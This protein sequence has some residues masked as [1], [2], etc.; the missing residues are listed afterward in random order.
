[1]LADNQ[2]LSH[3]PGC[4]CIHYFTCPESAVMKNHVVILTAS[5]FGLSLPTSANSEE[6][7]VAVAANFTTPM[8]VI[9]ADFEKSTGH[10]LVL[11]FGATGNFYAQIKNGGPYEVFLAAD[12]ETPAKL[13]QE[14]IAVPESRFSYAIGRLV[15]WSAKQGVVDDKGEVLKKGNFEHIA[16]A[17]PRLAPYGAAAKE[18]IDKLGLEQSIQQKLVIGE[19]ISQTYQ[20]VSTG[21]AELGFVALSQVYEDGKVKR[22]SAWIVP[23]NLHTAIRQDAIVL[24]RGK[25]NPAAKAL[26]EFLKSEK[27]RAVIKSYGYEL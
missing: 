1:M 12:D 19:N 7:L 24:K 10:K 8:K 15:L 5:L 20:F 17:N 6:V 11:S 16:I 9:A 2:R 14:H 18:V 22:G 26:I 25:D 21:N 13:E 27:T 3:N 23:A 4:I